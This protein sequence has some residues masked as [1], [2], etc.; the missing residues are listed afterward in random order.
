MALIIAT[1]GTLLYHVRN[2]PT[3]N[4]SVRKIVD[5]R[6]AIFG[7]G[8]AAAIITLQ[9][10]PADG[11]TQEI[12]LAIVLGEIGAISGFSFV[13]KHMNTMRNALKESKKRD[14]YFITSTDSD[15]GD[16]A[17]PTYGQVQTFE[18]T[19]TEPIT[20]IDEDQV[21][22]KMSI[23]QLK[24]GGWYKTNFRHDPKKGNVLEYGDKDL[25][26]QIPTA[27]HISGK[28]EKRTPGKAWKI[29]QIEQTG[30]P[31]NPWKN[32]LKFEMLKRNS[33]GAIESLPRGSYQIEISC[34]RPGKGYTQGIKSDFDII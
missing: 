18:T 14:S 25:I 33:S 6:L 34:S 5:A 2:L 3:G 15:Y 9:E 21:Q 32:M 10:I 23:P 27:T 26:I 8:V 11:L 22:L 4:F 29:I 17:K 19:K 20:A 13:A 31:S 16:R 1:S 28:L 12:Q 24:G 7:S 30:R